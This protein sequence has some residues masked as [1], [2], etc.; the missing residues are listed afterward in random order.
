M[1][2]A[3]IVTPAGPSL[4]VRGRSGYVD[5]AEGSQNPDYV[6]LAAVIEGGRAA[7]DVLAPLAE[8]D[9]TDYAESDLGAAVPDPKRVMCVGVNYLEHAIEG[10]REAPS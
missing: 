3:T 5:A 10:G 6:T 7:L 4:H 2:L 8:R 1:Q 9:G